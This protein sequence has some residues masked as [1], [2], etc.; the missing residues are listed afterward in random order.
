[1]SLS[2]TR[3]T[4]VDDLLHHTEGDPHRR[5][6]SLSD[7][8]LGA[9]DGLVNVLGVILGIAAATNDARIVLV[10][11]LAT[12]FAESISMGAVAFTTTLADADLYQS[13][14]ERE[15]RHIEEIPNLEKQ[16]VREIYKEKGFKG[17][18]L[19][20]IVET[21]TA[22]QDVW[23]AVMMAEEHQLSP[24][25]R[26]QAWRA[27]WVVG[28]SAVIGSLVPLAPFPFL[29]IGT[30]MWASVL[31][32]AAVLF[33]IG[34]YKAHVTVGRPMRSGV[35]MTIIGTLSALA[36]YAVGALLKVPAVP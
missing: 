35:E 31:I 1:M 23:V 14:Q 22:N 6:T 36:G 26:K 33:A 16:E 9:Q 29:P 7:F 21:V 8:I 2:K 25:D 12:T 27:A 5:A 17:E 28:I 24:I 32:T 20:H 15:Y 13:E 30:S 34:Y 18:L 4:S 19:D 3:H 11:G 10:A